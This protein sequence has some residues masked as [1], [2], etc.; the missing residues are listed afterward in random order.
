MPIPKSTPV[1]AI[2]RLLTALFQSSYA[3]SDLAYIQPNADY[4]RRLYQNPA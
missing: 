3:L 1:A 4:E 2:Y